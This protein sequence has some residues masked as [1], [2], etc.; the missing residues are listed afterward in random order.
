MSANF[1]SN[2]SLTLEVGF[3]SE[4]FDETQSFTDITSYLRA[5]TTRRGRAN[6]IGEF[7]SGTMSFSVSNADNRFNP[8]NTLSPYYDSSN[9]RTKIQPL[10]RVR[11]S[12]TY[13]SSTYVIF[14]GFLQ[15]VPVKFISEGA[16]SIVTFTCVDAFKIFQSVRLD[17]VGWRLGLAGFSELGQSTSLGYE[18]EQELSSARISRILDTI[19]FPSNRRDILTGT[20][21]VISQAITTNVLSGLRE[22]E[23][24]ENGQF[25]ISKDGKAT[26]RN[27][28]YKL[29]NTNAI[30]VQGTFSNDGS[31]LPYTN[32]STSFDD[33]EII[34]VYEW[35]RSGGTIQYKADADSVLRYRAKESNKTTINVSDG[36]VLSII[37][38]KIAE[39]SLPILRIDDL[40]C[41]PRENTSLW[42]Q[43]LGREFGDRI[44]V[45]IVNVDGSSFTDELW[46][47]S[48]S[49]NVNASNQSWSWTA[50]LSP[51]G[52]SA[53]ILG[54]AK[55]GEGTRLVYA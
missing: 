36:D 23:T 55:L 13:D 34:N 32:V 54:Q 24:A 15:S 12:A 14:E 35:Q 46:I 7:V 43:V 1:D 31:N 4:P 33:N 10:K 28:D 38:Q 21:Q 8:N 49:H 44:S 45:K 52:S 27:R 50:T 19:Q 3:D 48:I 2:V 20:K 5:F 26:F 53:W 6:E 40:T 11:M 41:N 18:D 37:E 25:F 9:A 29:S 30:N 47:E 16:D 22:C 42:Q 17:G 51:A 39:T